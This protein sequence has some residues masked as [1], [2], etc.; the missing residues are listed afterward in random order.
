MRSSREKPFSPPPGKEEG[1]L[2]KRKR[3]NENEKINRCRERNRIHAKNTRLRKRHQIDVLQQRIARLVYEKMRLRNLIPDE[4]VADILMSLSQLPISSS[5]GAFATFGEEFGEQNTLKTITT[6]QHEVLVNEASKDV[7]EIIE[8][9]KSSVTANISVRDIENDK[10]CMLLSTVG[11][12]R[13]KFSKED[14]NSIRRERNRR[15]AKK[16]RYRKKI[17]MIQMQD[18]IDTLEVDM[19]KLRVDYNLLGV[20]LFQKDGEQLRIPEFQTEFSELAGKDS[21]GRLE[22]GIDDE[23]EA[24]E[25]EQNIQDDRISTDAEEDI[26]TTLASRSNSRTENVDVKKISSQGISMDVKDERSANVFLNAKGV[27]KWNEEIIRTDQSTLKFED[28]CTNDLQE[29]YQIDAARNANPLEEKLTDRQQSGTSSSSSSKGFRS[30]SSLSTQEVNEREAMLLYA[31]TCKHS[32]NS[33]TS[34]ETSMSEKSTSP[35]RSSTSQ[36]VTVGHSG[37]QFC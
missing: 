8:N 2:G 35:P 21:N 25:D 33:L 9:L 20:D 37:S 30:L 12:D 28:L 23:D 31:E 32:T 4:S 24:S 15:H 10:N 7:I 5:S 18:V 6:E 3:Y 27:V 22:E 13:N 26:S 36:W 1:G 19:T 16:T 34:G 17:M 11:I 14:L 29:L